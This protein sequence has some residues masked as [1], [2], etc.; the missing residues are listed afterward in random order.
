MLRTLLIAGYH[1]NTGNFLKAREIADDAGY[2]F[3]WIEAVRKH[4][5]RHL[6]KISNIYHTYYTIF[7]AIM[8]FTMY[9]TGRKEEIPKFTT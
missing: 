5:I 7:C 9:L 4:E 2:Y 8:V 6:K 1:Y 3:R